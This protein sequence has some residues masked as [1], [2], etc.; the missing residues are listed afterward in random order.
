MKKLMSILLAFVMLCSITPFALAASTEA[1]EAANALN[2]L[3]LFEGGGTN[4]DGTINY[5]LDRIPTVQV[6][7]TT[8][9]K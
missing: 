8:R 3:G 6:K 1:T 2:A 5:E 4:A 7:I 9:F